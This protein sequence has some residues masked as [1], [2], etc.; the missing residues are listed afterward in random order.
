M[1]ALAVS[2]PQQFL[3]FL[4]G[5]FGQPL[6]IRNAQVAIANLLDQFWCRLADRLDQLNIGGV[7]LRNAGGNAAGFPFAVRGELSTC[8][9]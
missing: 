6:R 1:V 5:D 9:C 3:P 2:L 8:F 4:L 7:G